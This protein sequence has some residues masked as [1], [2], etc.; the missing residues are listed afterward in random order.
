MLLPRRPISHN[1]PND[2]DLS[3]RHYHHVA[4]GDDHHESGSFDPILDHLCLPPYALIDMAS[5]RGKWPSCSTYE[6]RMCRACRDYG[7]LEASAA[8][9]ACAA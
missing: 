1:D 5:E 6:T 3:D 2:P 4:G 9:R 8:A 7:D